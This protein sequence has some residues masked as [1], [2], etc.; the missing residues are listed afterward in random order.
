MVSIDSYINSA[1]EGAFGRLEN[2]GVGRELSGL[3][4]GELVNKKLVCAAV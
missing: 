4:I 2:S 3:G 1:S